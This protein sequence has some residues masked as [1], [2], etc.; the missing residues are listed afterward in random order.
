MSGVLAVLEQRDSSLEALAAAQ[1]I[2]AE[3][4]LPVFAAVLGSS[5]ETFAQTLTGYKLNKIHA[6]DHELLQSYTPDG[7]TIALK[8]LIEAHHP[9]YVLFPHTYQVRDFVPKLATT[10]DRVLVSDVISHRID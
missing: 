8:Q 10:L 5:V 6:I 1:Q 9:Q 4:S 2:S 7:Y 3:L